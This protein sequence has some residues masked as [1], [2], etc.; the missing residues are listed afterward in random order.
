VLR[1]F[2]LRETAYGLDV[3]FSE[4]RLLERYNSELANDLGNLTSR[5]LSMAQRYFG[6]EIKAPVG[7]RAEDRALGDVFASLPE[8]VGTLTDELGFNRALEVVW[9]ALDLANK[10]IVA[11]S[12]FTL[13]RDVAQLPRVAEIIATLIEGLRVVAD[14]LEPFM[15]V[16]SARLLDLLGADQVTAR[17]PYGEGF[18]PGHRVNAPV[19]LFPRI[20]KPRA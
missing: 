8:K 2:V 19:P 11:T 1:Y 16:T 15:P 9:Q 7:A 12:P 6:G 5:V 4:E 20:E 10:Y 18:K 3:D 13:A 14:T 17:T